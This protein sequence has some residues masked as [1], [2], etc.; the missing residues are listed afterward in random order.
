MGVFDRLFRGSGNKVAHPYTALQT[1]VHSHL[2][3][4]IDDGASDMAES[5]EMARNMVALGYRRAIVTPHIMSDAYPNT[6]EEILAVADRL[7]TALAEHGIPLEI[8]CGAEYYLDEWFLEHTTHPDLLC[9][10]GEARYLLFETSYVSKPM[11]LTEAVFNLK[12]NG[13]Q[14]VMAHPERYQYFWS[15]DA[16]EEIEHLHVAGLLMQV[17]ITSFAGSR[18]KRA[19][20]I[21]HEM[22]TKGMVS[23]LGT[24]MHKPLQVNSLHNAFAASKDLQLLVES[25]QLLNSRL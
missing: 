17:N 15:Q 12:A 2:L 8:E 18:G 21:A 22:A 16:M 11:F 6:P 5:L 24:D 1:D 19:S 7:R 14:P 13:Y 9:W 20:K 23:F 25:G 3:P 10:G 4:G